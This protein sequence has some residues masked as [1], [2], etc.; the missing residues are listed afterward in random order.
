M[1]NVEHI[2]KKQILFHLFY[3]KSYVNKSQNV[4][5]FYQL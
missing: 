4:I 2:L 1:R 3:Q 5:G